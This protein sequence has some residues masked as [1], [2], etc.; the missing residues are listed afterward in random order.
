MAAIFYI[1][2]SIRLL[3]SFFVVTKDFIIIFFLF[4]NENLTKGRIPASYLY[5]NSK[6]ETISSLSQLNTIVNF[7]E[8]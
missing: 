8:F 4:I 2:F 6:N 1:A 7:L 3:F 5:T